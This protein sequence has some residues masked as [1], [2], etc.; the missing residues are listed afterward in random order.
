MRVALFF[1]VSFFSFFF[2][3]L[4][5][6]IAGR[7]HLDLRAQATKRTSTN[8]RMSASSYNTSSRT[9]DTSRRLRYRS[10]GPLPLVSDGSDCTC[11][12]FIMSVKHQLS[13]E[14][15]GKSMPWLVLR[16]EDGVV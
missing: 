1:F 5:H 11:C 13:A 10:A 4:L 12:N 3:A 14:G 15:A 6:G 8:Q 9:Y 2:S 7:L 16:T